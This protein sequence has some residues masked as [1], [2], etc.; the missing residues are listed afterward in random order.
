M[1][2]EGRGPTQ[3]TLA[4]ERMKAVSADVRDLPENYRRHPDVCGQNKLSI[5]KSECAKAN[6]IE[7]IFLVCRALH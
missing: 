7:D 1:D 3:R 4:M 2:E 6:K 5:K